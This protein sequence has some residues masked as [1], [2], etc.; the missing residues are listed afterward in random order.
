M[1]VSV[2]LSSAE[3]TVAAEIPS[4]IDLWKTQAFKEILCFASGKVK[5]LLQPLLGAVC[6]KEKQNTVVC[7]VSVLSV[8]GLDLSAIIC[9][10]KFLFH[11]TLE[12]SMQLIY[13]K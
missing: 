11:L 4:F 2:S 3:D 5:D 1:S 9:Q 13:L 8:I 6:V 10:A 7:F 12:C